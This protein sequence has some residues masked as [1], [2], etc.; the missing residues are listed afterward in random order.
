MA[1]AMYWDPIAYRFCVEAGVGGTINL[2][3]GGKCGV[4][5]G[6]PV[7]LR[8]TVKG[9][10]RELTQLFGT[11]PWPLGDAAWVTTD[12]G[13]DLI[14]NTVRTQVFHPD[15]MTALGLN[16]SERRIVIVKSNYHFQAGFAPIAKRILFCAQPGA[17]QPNFA[18]I[19]YTKLKTP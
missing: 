2:R 17:T 13:I 16:P 11:M 18:A 7:D 9:L 8:V 12:G 1:S 5:S 19:P 15:C 3:V 14:I 10:G 6:M 4:F